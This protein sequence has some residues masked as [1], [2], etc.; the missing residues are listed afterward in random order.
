MKNIYVWDGIEN[1]CGVVAQV[2]IFSE[3]TVIKINRGD[4]SVSVNYVT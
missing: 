1:S 4:V 2:F 3:V